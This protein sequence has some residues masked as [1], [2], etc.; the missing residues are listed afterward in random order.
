MLTVTALTQPPSHDWDATLVASPTAAIFQSAAW[1]RYLADSGHDVLRFVAHD[2]DGI[3]VACLL[4]HVEHLRLEAMTGQLAGIA[5]SAVRKLL[6]VLRWQHGPVVLDATRHSE[7]AA[8]LADAV[9]TW[10]SDHKVHQVKSASLPV[11]DM[12]PTQATQP[13]GSTDFTVSTWGTFLVELTGDEDTLYNGMRRNARKSVKKAMEQGV[14]VTRASTVEELRDYDAL[15]RQTRRHLGLGMPPHY[16]DLAMWEQLHADGHLELFLARKDR[17]LIAGMGAIVFNGGIVEIAL[18]RDYDAELSNC[19]GDLI[20][21]ELMRW[22]LSTGQRYYDLAGV[23]PNP[24]SPKEQNIRQYK[25]KFGGR[26]VE[27]PVINKTYARPGGRLIRKLQG[28][29][30]A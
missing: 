4:A 26:F 1:G 27:Y 25:A 11:C 7:A 30:G 16:P 10:C 19:T 29:A 6:P 9:D 22:G 21:W 17:Q 12:D 2:E 24:E 13:W 8:S 14:E 20:K 23:S 5:A 3:P 28:V 18:A 15:L